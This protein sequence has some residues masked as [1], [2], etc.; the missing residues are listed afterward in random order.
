M[1]VEVGFWAGDRSWDEMRIPLWEIVTME[2][3]VSMLTRWLDPQ[4]ASCAVRRAWA[5]LEPFVH[6]LVESLCLKGIPML[7]YRP[8][9]RLYADVNTALSQASFFRQFQRQCLYGYLNA[10]LKNPYPHDH[11]V[12]FHNPDSHDRYCKSNTTFGNAQLLSVH[13]SALISSNPNPDVLLC[14][15]G[16]VS[17][18]PRNPRATLISKL[19]RRAWNDWRGPKA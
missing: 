3:R 11:V 16:P 9:Y 7:D 1:G 18:L 5:A 2:T 10:A 4:Y 8:C 17:R 6:S 15:L 14:N 12:S 19:E 13:S